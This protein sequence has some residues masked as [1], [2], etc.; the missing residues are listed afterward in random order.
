VTAAESV[1][2]AAYPEDVFGEDPKSVRSEYRRLA[3]ELHPD[4]ENGSKAA[5]QALNE[6]YERAR[7]AIA[8]GK[9]GE[10]VS[11]AGALVVRSRRR[12][13]RIE[14]VLVKGSTATL[15]RATFED[16]SG[17]APEQV[18][19]I[20]KVVR[21]PRKG[22]K[23]QAEAHALG[24]ILKADRIGDLVEMYLPRYVEA[25]GIRR[26]RKTHQALAFRRSPSAVTLSEVVRAF[27]NGV[28]P[29][30]SAWIARRLLYSLGLVH[31]EG[32]AHGGLSQTSHI[33]ILP[34]KHG[35]ILWDWSSARKVSE[36]TR[37]LD[38]AAAIRKVVLVTRPG[39]P[40]RLASWYR[41][42]G[43]DANA[44]RFP[45]ALDLLAEYDE[46][47]ED[48]WGRRQFRPFAMPAVPA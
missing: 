44:R 17:D 15:Y 2:A 35:V 11:V 22:E 34:E 38:V 42:V 21:D 41:Y 5:F 20:V 3:I 37:A 26:G 18:P 25:F 29:R 46:L 27:P 47:I 14:G 23:L 32:Y 19:A 4:H 8:D 48:L 28:D 33:L 36:E 10:R 16:E 6:L 13:Y 9:Y 43:D 45:P 31:A 40:R 30:D 39:L 1:I 7:A 12:A 24:A